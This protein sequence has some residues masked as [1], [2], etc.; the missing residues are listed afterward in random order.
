MK[1]LYNYSGLDPEGQV[2]QTE[3]EAYQRIYDTWAEENK[4]LIYRRNP[5]NLEEVKAKQTLGEME[6]KLQSLTDAVAEFH[7]VDM[8]GEGELTHVYSDGPSVYGV[9]AAE[10]GSFINVDLR[11]LR[12]KGNSEVCIEGPDVR[13][14]ADSIMDD[15]N[16]IALTTEDKPSV[17]TKKTGSK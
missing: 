2:A 12:H 8:T 4:L 15:L 5:R 13:H 17:R 7:S 16:K 11:E 14:L 9:V 10:D 6:E 3:R 1:V